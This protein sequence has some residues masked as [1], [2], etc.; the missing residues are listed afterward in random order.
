VLRPGGRLVVGID[1][2]DDPTAARS[3]ESKSG[4]HAWTP[5]EFGALLAQAGF[6]DVTMAPLRGRAYARAVRP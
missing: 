2:V 6:E 1:T 3:F 5:R 4:L